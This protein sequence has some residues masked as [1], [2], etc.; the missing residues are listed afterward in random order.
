[1]SKFGPE[2]KVKAVEMYLN[3]TFSASQI[4]EKLKCADSSIKKWIAFFRQYGPDY[5]IPQKGNNSYTAEFKE[6]LVLEYLSGEG[7]L[8]SLAVK[9][10]VPSKQKIYN[11]I[12]VYNANMELKDYIPAGEVYMADSRR[13]TTI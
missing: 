5:F 4:S 10:K 7:S 6:R 12:N 3:G 2:D 1:M 8:L 13:K 11:W 9:Y